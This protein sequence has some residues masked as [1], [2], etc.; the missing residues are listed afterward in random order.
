MSEHEEL[1]ATQ[2][3]RERALLRALREADDRVFEH[4]SSDYDDEDYNDGDG[5]IVEDEDLIE[6]REGVLN[7][8]IELGDLYDDLGNFERRRDVLLRLLPLLERRLD[9][10]QHVDFAYNLAELGRAHHVLG[11]DNDA[12]ICLERSLDIYEGSGK[13][14]TGKWLLFFGFT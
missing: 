8:L 11:Q 7:A 1:E 3:R 10:D 12:C 5:K 13:T 9:T 14:N 6:Q 4:E 2:L